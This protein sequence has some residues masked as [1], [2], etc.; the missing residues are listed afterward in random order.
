MRTKQRVAVTALSMSIFV[1]A[2]MAAASSDGLNVARKGTAPYH[3]IDAAI[4]DGYG[5][6]TD[7]DGIA[8]ID[9]PGEGGMGIHYVKG[10]LVG[11]PAEN[12]A[13]PEALVYEPQRNGRL[14]LVAV[15]W[16]VL[17]ADWEGAGNT[18][19]P[20]LFGQEF[21]LVGADNRYGLPPFYELHAWI[22]RHNPSG[23][24]NDWNPRVTCANA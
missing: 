11:D 18:E 17:Q 4:A 24:F 9:K 1:L 15:E 7:K 6:F 22:W 16:V 5:L 12:A 14:R 19:P 23:M 20:S 13:T 2:G 21:T 8:C 10:A 3:R